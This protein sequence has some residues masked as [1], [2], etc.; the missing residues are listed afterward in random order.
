MEIANGVEAD[1]IVYR[2]WLDEPDWVVCV[3]APDGRRLEKRF[4]WM[5]HPVFGPDVGDI[6]IAER[7]MERMIRELRGGSSSEPVERAGTK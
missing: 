6:G 3:T 2:C 1:G 5:A 4:R 7:T